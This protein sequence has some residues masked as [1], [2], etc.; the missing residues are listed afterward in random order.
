MMQLIDVC[1]C[2]TLTNGRSAM[3][4]AMFSG[5][6]PLTRTPDGAYFIDRAGTQF[7][8]CGT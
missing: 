8:Q 3:L 1:V 4:G 7:S 2:S 5:H 6:V